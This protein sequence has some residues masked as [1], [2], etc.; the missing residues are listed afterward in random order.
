L[1]IGGTLLLAENETLGRTWE[2]D[3]KYLHVSSS[4]TNVSVSPSIIRYPSYVTDEMTPILVYATYCWS[5]GECHQSIFQHYLGHC[6]IKPENILLDDHFIAWKFSFSCF[7]FKMMEEGKVRDIVDSE[8]DD[9][10]H[11]AIS[12][13]L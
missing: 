6:D 10:V 11:C 3:Q 2:N 7:A 9:K 1:N 5:N 13:A 12:I 8:H 4:I